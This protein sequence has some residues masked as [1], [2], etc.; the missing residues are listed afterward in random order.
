MV[1]SDSFMTVMGKKNKRVDKYYLVKR[2]IKGEDEGV[3]ADHAMRVCPRVW[4]GP[5]Q[6]RVRLQ[7]QWNKTILEELGTNIS[8]LA[9]KYNKCLAQVDRLFREKNFHVLG[10]KRIIGCTTTAAAMYIDEIRKASPGIVLVEEAGEILES[11]ILTA[12]TPTTKLLIMI[13]DHKQLRPKVN[14]YALAE[15]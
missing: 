2:W 4:D 12:L 15:L 5:P 11:H 10:Q 9:D 8:T 6:T 1:G 7:A 14:N 13:G 3:F